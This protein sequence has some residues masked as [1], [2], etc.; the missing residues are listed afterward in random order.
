MRIAFLGSEGIPYPNAFAK[1]TEEIGA[2]LVERGHD[3]VVFGRRHL[4][5]E[6]SPYRGMLRVPVRSWNS[7]HLDTLSSTFLSSLKLLSSGWADIAHFHG[8]GPAVL[9]GLP[10]LRGT[11]SVVH[12]HAQDWRRAKWGRLA[13]KYLQ[14]SE[15]AAIRLPDA[16]VVVSNELREYVERRYGRSVYYV[17]Q[18][19]DQP[20][21]QAP[22]EILALGLKPQEYL[23][24]MGRL[25]PEKG[26]H[27]LMEAYRRLSMQNGGRILPLVVAG[28]A[29]HTDE[30]V[31]SL[32]KTAP[33]EVSFLGHVTG[34]S[35]D[36]LLSHAYAFVQ[37]SELEGL[38]LGLLEAMS[39]GNA[40]L[41][42]DIPENVEAAGSAAAYFRSRDVDDL[43][44]RIGEFLDQPERVHELRERAAARA[45]SRHSW[46]VVTS[47]MENVY[48]S[49]LRSAESGR[50]RKR[51]GA[52]L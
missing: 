4:V 51:D 20:N 21:R 7:K 6:S 19:V 2:R 42:S 49:V 35:K 24:F 12:F 16:T 29:A 37:P 45:A 9:A 44:R 15:V 43:V 25:V 10:K 28:G 36:E 3:V 39:Y 38:S 47:E 50:I 22:S 33:P 41:A 17:P 52:A 5:P 27:H 40:V 18:G 32:R 8:I 31:R 30:Y 1:I 11:R 23:L 48:E 26:L 13:R 46:D 34:R 14:M